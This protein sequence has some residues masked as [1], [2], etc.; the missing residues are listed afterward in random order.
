[1]P[2]AHRHPPPNAAYL[3]MNIIN[4]LGADGAP[5]GLVP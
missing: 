1:M 2:K 5:A 4:D 3:S